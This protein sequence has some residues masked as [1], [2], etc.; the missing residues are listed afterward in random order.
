MT[1]SVRPSGAKEAM[2]RRPSCATKASWRPDD[3]HATSLIHARDTCGSEVSEENSVP[4][5]GARNRAPRS[6]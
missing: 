3:D 2:W 6:R 1:G 4:P 5:T